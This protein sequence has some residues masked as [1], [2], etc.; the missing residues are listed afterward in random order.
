MPKIG[1]ILMMTPIRM[2]LNLIWKIYKVSVIQLFQRYT[3]KVVDRVKEDMMMK[4]TK[5]FEKDVSY[6][7]QL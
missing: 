1:S 2:T 3:K 7:V 4:I 5:I 6:L